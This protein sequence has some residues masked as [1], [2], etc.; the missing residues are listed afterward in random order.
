M[1]MNYKIIFLNFWSILFGV[2]PVPNEARSKM[3]GILKDY[4]ENNPQKVYITW[5]EM[6]DLFKE[7]Q[8]KPLLS[9]IGERMIKAY[10]ATIANANRDVLDIPNVNIEK[11]VTAD[12]VSIDDIKN[13]F[14]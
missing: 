5:A 4:F 6:R 1:A 3:I 13:I 2:T 10:I 8:V 12:D 9:G 7:Q 11:D 14:G